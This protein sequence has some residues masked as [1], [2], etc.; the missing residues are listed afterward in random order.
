MPK[1][2]PFLLRVLRASL[3]RS[4]GKAHGSASRARKVHKFRELYPW[5]LLGLT[6]TPHKRTPDDQI[7]YRY[8]LFAAIAD[9]LVKTPVIVGRKDDRT[10]SLTKV[11]RRRDLAPRQGRRRS[12]PCLLS[13][14]KQS[15]P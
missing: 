8:P 1:A 12:Y 7:V 3:N 5:L 13:E 9:K 10:D 6:A 2:P 15:I 4:G 11:G 14:A